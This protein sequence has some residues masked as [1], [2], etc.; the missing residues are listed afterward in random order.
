MQRL[1]F[2]LNLM[3]GLNDSSCII[4]VTGP[5][6]V[7]ALIYMLNFKHVTSSTHFNGTIDVSDIKHMLKYFGWPEAW[8]NI[9]FYGYATCLLKIFMWI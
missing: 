9:L 8:L 1:L 4:A 5:G 6:P 2:K 7:K 3:A